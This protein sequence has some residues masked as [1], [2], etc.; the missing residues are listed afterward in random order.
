MKN[1]D[2]LADYYRMTGTKFSFL[3]GIKTVIFCHNVR[4]MYWWR[5]RDK[6]PNNI[7]A[8]IMCYRLSRK[9]GLE[10]GSCKIGPGLYIGHPYNVTVSSYAVIGKN[11]NLNKGVTIGNINSGKRKGCP[12]IGDNVYVG[13]NSTVVGG[14]TIGNDVV[15]APNAFVNF[16]VPDH[17]VVVGNPGVIHHKD[18][19]SLGYIGFTRWME[20]K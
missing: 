6:S 9:Y 5:K 11:V 14:I 7:I 20:D 4:F 3:K 17:S 2:F 16:D 15:I 10:I 18:N 8:K 12:K 13:I 1:K 19:A